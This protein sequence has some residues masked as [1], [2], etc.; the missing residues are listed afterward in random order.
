MFRKFP[1]F[2]LLLIGLASFGFV[3]QLI[4]KTTDLLKS[5]LMTALF[6]GL[7]FAVLYFLF[8]RPRTSS[9]SSKY[10]KA[11]KQSRK[12]YGASIRKKA[13]A[14]KNKHK[15]SPLNRPRPNPPHLKVIDGKRSKNRVGGGG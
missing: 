10:K 1:L 3:H 13:T 7:V 14:P 15:P 9:L 11:V 5:L 8:I 2:I 6:I 12:K 4:F